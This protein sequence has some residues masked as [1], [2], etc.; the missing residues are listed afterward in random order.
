MKKHGYPKRKFRYSTQKPFSI[1]TKKP[2]KLTDFEMHD[3]L[4]P[5]ALPDDEDWLEKMLE[6]FEGYESVNQKQ[7]E[8]DEIFGDAPRRSKPL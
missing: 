6:N 8:L 2:F 7:K 5:P 1:Y 4:L 3:L